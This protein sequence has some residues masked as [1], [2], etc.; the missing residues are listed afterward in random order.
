MV[1]SLPTLSYMFNTLDSH[2]SIAQVLQQDWAQ[3]GV[4]VELSNQEWKVFKQLEMKD[5]MKL[6]DMV[7]S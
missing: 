5:N 1:K 6:L 4:N 3:I 7:G 2:K